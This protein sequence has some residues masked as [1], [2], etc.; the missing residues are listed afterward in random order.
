MNKL[1]VLLDTVSSYLNKDTGDAKGRK[2][3][4]SKVNVKIIEEEDVMECMRSFCNDQQVDINLRLF[5]LEELKK[6]FKNMNEQDLMLLLVY[7]TNAI[8]MNCGQFNKK[9]D[10][11]EASSIEN[12]LERRNLLDKLIGFSETNE[13]YL[14]L[15]SLLKI[16]PEFQADYEHKPWNLVIL[17]T[18]VNGYPFIETVAE[19]KNKNK[20]NSDSDLAYIKTELENDQKWS[21]SDGKLKVS[22]LKL[23]ALFK[24]AKMMNKFIEELGIDFSELNNTDYD[25][26]GLENSQIIESI[27]NDEEL[28]KLILVDKLYTKLVNT[29]IFTLLIYHVVKNQTKQEILEIV[30]TLKKNGYICEAGKLLIDAENFYGSYRSISA[31]MA[32]IEKFS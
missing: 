12:E 29:H 3:S 8:L 31:S 1:Q 21:N 25:Y 30:R 22:Y 32:L 26:T 28:F 10:Q 14:G 17:K 19:L 7:K 15:I 2:K 16:W 23:L 20:F 4:Q 5:I 6:S 24:E 13:H 9:I 18:I 11:I 27:L